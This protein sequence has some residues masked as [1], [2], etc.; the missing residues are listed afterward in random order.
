MGSQGSAGTEL[1]GHRLG[2]LVKQVGESLS[3][4]QRGVRARPGHARGCSHLAQKC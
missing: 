1:N 3:G 2:D 4:R